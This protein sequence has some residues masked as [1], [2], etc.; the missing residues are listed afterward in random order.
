M[1]PS[2]AELS[3]LLRR[4]QAVVATMVQQGHSGAE[5]AGS[6]ADLVHQLIPQAQVTACLLV[7]E[8]DGCL[9]V[10]PETA[11]THLEQIRSALP[12]T[13]S[14]NAQVTGVRVLPDAPV[15]GMCLLLTPFHE[16]EHLRG[17]LVVG[18]ATDHDAEEQPR[19]ENLLTLTGPLIGM[20]IELERERTERAELARF[21]LLGQAFA[22]LAHDLNNALNS[23]MLQTSVVQLRVDAQARQ[24]LAAI[25]QHGVQAAALV[26]SLQQV[27][28]ERREQSYAVDLN[29]AVTEVLEEEAELARHVSTTLSRAVPQ[30]QTTRTALKLLIRLILEGVCAGTKLPVRVATESSGGVASLVL[31]F[32]HEAEASEL[33]SAEELLWRNLDDL[34]RQAGQSLLRQL[35][36]TLAVERSS[37][38][39]LVSRITWQ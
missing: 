9:A 26:R 29:T 19:V 12:R 34:R 30:L 13:S 39:E 22:G 8:G 37:A 1:T 6:L 35:S 4:C 24:D 21:A 20:G 14:I 28:Q 16:G 17:F 10:R 23:M 5:R 18:L 15:P 27:V 31:T 7:G 36:G 38:G 25:R 3:D 32:A 2:A 33:P 11:T